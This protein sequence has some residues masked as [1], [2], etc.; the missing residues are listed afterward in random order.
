MQQPWQRFR[1]TALLLV[2]ALAS[3]C[4]GMATQKIIAKTL[5]EKQSYHNYYTNQQYETLDESLQA[6]RAHFN[7]ELAGVKPLGK[8]LKCKSLLLIPSITAIT[9]EYDKLRKLSQGK[10]EMEMRTTIPDYDRVEARREKFKQ[11][12]P[13]FQKVETKLAES[14]EQIRNHYAKM[15]EIRYDIL[16]E[17]LNRRKIFAQTTVQKTNELGSSHASAAPGYGCTIY[18]VSR[19]M[20]GK[21]T[22]AEKSW[23]LKTPG[24]E[25]SVMIGP[26]EMINPW[27]SN[28]EKT[29]REQLPGE[30]P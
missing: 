29:A 2:L 13:E 25:D 28:V 15:E 19:I 9:N 5:N 10:V 14:L 8:P 12:H 1:L 22:L 7:K 6:T 26:D 17:A 21:V 30:K 27:L 16:A 18:L 11:N 3:G 4:V 23:F 20:P 24:C